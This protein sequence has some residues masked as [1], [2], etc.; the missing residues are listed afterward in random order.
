MIGKYIGDS[1]DLLLYEADKFKLSIQYDWLWRL[2]ISD[3][4]VTMILIYVE[5]VI[6][7]YFCYYSKVHFFFLFLFIFFLSLPFLSIFVCVVNYIVFWWF[8]YRVDMYV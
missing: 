1:S 4:V 3:E 8:N 5:K 7:S 6:N 2:P